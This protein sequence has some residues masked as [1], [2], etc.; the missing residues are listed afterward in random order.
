M[1]T[2]YVQIDVYGNDDGDPT[3]CDGGRYVVT[4]DHSS[5]Q[6]K[7][8]WEEVKEELLGKDDPWDSPEQLIE[9]M[10]ER[11]YSITEDDAETITV[12]A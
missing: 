8:D 7:K 1:S 11:G 10:E 6:F 5:S 9:K 4:S 12:R 2:F 3:V